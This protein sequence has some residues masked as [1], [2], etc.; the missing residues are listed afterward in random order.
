MQP[1]VS[2]APQRAPVLSS[3]TP[4]RQAGHAPRLPHAASLAIIAVT[5]ACSNNSGPPQATG[6]MPSAGT[7]GAS[8]GGTGGAGCSA[9]KPSECGSATSSA[10]RG[11][12]SMGG[13]GGSAAG[14]AGGSSPVGGSGGS[15]SLALV[16]AYDGQRGTAFNDGCKFHLG[17][18]T[19]AE[20]P[21]FSTA[22]T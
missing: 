16:Q 7:G 12:V 1:S 22:C 21:A 13:T 3:Q 15:S 9:G 20:D 8:V 5:L 10:G 19:G 6:G 17:D 4:T 14:G 11:A 18:S 2:D